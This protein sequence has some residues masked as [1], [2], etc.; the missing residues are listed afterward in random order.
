MSRAET[1]RRRLA[2]ATLAAVLAAIAASPAAAIPPAY[3][4]APAD[5]A[6]WEPH[7][8]HEMSPIKGLGT[9]ETL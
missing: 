4:N 5:S 7:G 6:A 2:V 9:V 1:R 3:A 8:V